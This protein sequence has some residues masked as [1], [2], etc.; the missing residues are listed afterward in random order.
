MYYLCIDKVAI[1][2]LII[3]DNYDDSCGWR[4]RCNGK[5]VG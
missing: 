1:N 2:K 3:G 4:K 5:I